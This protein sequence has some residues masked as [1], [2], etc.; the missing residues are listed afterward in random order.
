M[1]VVGCTFG[2]ALAVYSRPWLDCLLPLQGVT[3]RDVGN[4][5]IP[6]GEWGFAPFVW[7]YGDG[8][9][10]SAANTNEVRRGA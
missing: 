1:R 10:F 2:V 4:V 8:A 9:R 3:T 5:S 6:Q 7:P